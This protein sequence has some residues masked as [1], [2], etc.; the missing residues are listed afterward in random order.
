VAQRLQAAV[1]A[2]ESAKALAAEV[3]E[4]SCFSKVSA[5]ILVVAFYSRLKGLL[6]PRV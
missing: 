3:T 5:Q 2:L 4:P 1:N 6:H